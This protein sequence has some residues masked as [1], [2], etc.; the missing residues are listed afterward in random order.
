M[1]VNMPRRTDPLTGKAIN[2]CGRIFRYA[3]GKGLA[4]RD[5]SRDKS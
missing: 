2:I 1:G 5:P 4:T 3:V